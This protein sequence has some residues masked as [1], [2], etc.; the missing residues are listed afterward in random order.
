[1]TDRCSFVAFS[2]FTVLPYDNLYS[3][4]DDLD[5]I[6]VIIV[7]QESDAADDINDGSEDCEDI[8]NVHMETAEMKLNTTLTEL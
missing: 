5:W 2:Y 3:L 8:D 6:A 4:I 7:M 1:M